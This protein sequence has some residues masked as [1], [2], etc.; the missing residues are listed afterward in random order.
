MSEVNWVTG[1]DRI[2]EREP[3]PLRFLLQDSRTRT[4]VGET[5]GRS[6][7]S[8]WGESLSR[9][10]HHNLHCP[11]SSPPPPSPPSL[12]PYL[13]FPLPLVLITAH[14]HG[15]G[16]PGASGTKHCLHHGCST[17]KRLSEHLNISFASLTAT[18][19]L[20]PHCH[21]ASHHQVKAVRR[22]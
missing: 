8:V 3:R 4:L 17:G 2:Q 22:Q 1:M 20:P 6:V 12:P 13:A 10:L 15:G 5:E 11:A 7:S 16:R 14:V 18:R 19:S 21:T 9:S